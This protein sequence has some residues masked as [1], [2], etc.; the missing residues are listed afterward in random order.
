MFLN[1][2][3]D[4]DGGVG[5]GGGVMNSHFFGWGVGP[6]LCQV[7]DVFRFSKFKHV[8]ILTV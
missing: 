1:S 4:K 6:P 7:P 5:E 2:L 8:H 3:K